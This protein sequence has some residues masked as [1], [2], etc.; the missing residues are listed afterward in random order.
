MI[1]RLLQKHIVRQH[2]AVH[3][4]EKFPP[5]KSSKRFHIKN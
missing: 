2:G 3:G 1:D 4:R 5:K